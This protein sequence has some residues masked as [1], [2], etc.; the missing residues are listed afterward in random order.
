MTSAIHPRIDLIEAAQRLLPLMTGEARQGRTNLFA[1]AAEMVFAGK[2]A[3]QVIAEL[4]HHDG[5]APGTVDY[6]PKLR[7]H[8][9]FMHIFE[10]VYH[11]PNRDLNYSNYGFPPPKV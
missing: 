10:Q 2:T 5:K 11:S 1:A 7:N 6:T 9:D 8:R 4:R 3:D